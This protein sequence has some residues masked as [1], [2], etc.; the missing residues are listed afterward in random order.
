MA[1]DAFNSPRDS[2][3]M[4]ARVA[5]LLFEVHAEALAQEWL[6]VDE[7]CRDRVASCLPGAQAS[8]ITPA[9]T[10]AVT[11]V[12][13]TSGFAS[14]RGRGADHNFPLPAVNAHAA[15]ATD[16]DHA[17]ATGRAWGRRRVNLCS[18]LHVIYERQSWRPMT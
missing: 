6:I 7:D 5:S 11:P 16:L 13:K 1:A 4:I 12:L 17:G 3:A 18:H 10:T 14:R 2:A 8:G 15:F 9:E